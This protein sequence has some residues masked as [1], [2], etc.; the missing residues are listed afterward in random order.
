MH[1]VLLQL[2]SLVEELAGTA[3]SRQPLPQEKYEHWHRQVAVQTVQ[4]KEI[5]LRQV[6]EQKERD[7]LQLYIQNVQMLLTQLLNKSS[8]LSE[9]L[10]A[11]LAPLL[12]SLQD[13]LNRVLDL[14]EYHLT[15]YFSRDQVLPDSHQH[16]IIPGFSAQMQ[17]IRQQYA[18]ADAELIRITLQPV[19]D[20]CDGKFSISYR[21]RDY[22]TSLLRELQEASFPDNASVTGWLQKKNF[23]DTSFLQYCIRQMQNETEEADSME[24]RLEKYR[25]FLKNT[26]QWYIPPTPALY[27]D[28]HSV[29]WQLRNWLKEEI[30]YLQLILADQAKLTT[31]PANPMKED[32]KINIS[33]SVG[34]LAFFI[35]LLQLV[36]II[37][38]T[39]QSDVLRFFAAY[40]RT[41]KQENISF[42]SLKNRYDAPLLGAVN[43][44]REIMRNLLKSTEK[45]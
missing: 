7:G 21:Q 19:Q 40:F 23:N 36:G 22:Y 5:L 33:V 43:T 11:A 15:G 13:G 41:A 16:K 29:Q 6:L 32:S 3:A 37:T 1:Q 35:R 45:F 10:P 14:L 28:L 12:S 9:T 4:I 31:H 27:P 20:F 39:N 42:K 44:T 24:D 18:A 8:L 25:L 34:V 26:N 2:D 30:R 38:N 17:L